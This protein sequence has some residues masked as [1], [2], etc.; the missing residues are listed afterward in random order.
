VHY[1]E[2]TNFYS[3]LLRSY[4]CTRGG[5]GEKALQL[6]DCCAATAER[7]VLKAK[8][9]CIFIQLLVKLFLLLFMRRPK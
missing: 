5:E 6:H 3:R 1:F 7:A 8:K 9:L 2:L 4:S